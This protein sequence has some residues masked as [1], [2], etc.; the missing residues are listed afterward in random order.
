MPERDRVSVR[1]KPITSRAKPV[2]ISEAA[3][4]PKAACQCPPTRGLEA[5]VVSPAVSSGCFWSLLQNPLRL[6]VLNVQLVSHR[7]VDEVAELRVSIEAQ[8]SLYLRE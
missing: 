2:S 8:L 4:T 6:K 5:P 1:A 3:Y 7:T